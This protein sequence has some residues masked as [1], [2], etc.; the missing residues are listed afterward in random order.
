MSVCT[1]VIFLGG[2]KKCKWFLSGK[3]KRHVCVWPILPVE[4]FSVCLLYPTAPWVF[5]RGYG[6][7][8]GRWRNSLLEGEVSILGEWQS[9]HILQSP[10]LLGE[11]STLASVGCWGIFLSIILLFIYLLFFFY[12]SAADF[13]V[14]PHICDTTSQAMLTLVCFTRI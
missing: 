10:L 1:C 3:R 7:L 11:W 12:I 9:T 2:R 8:S 4:M 14:T 13:L 6:S 5:A